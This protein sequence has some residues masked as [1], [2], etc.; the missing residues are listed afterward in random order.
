MRVLQLI[1]SSGYYGA[2]SMLVTL[3]AELSPAS[4]IATVGALRVG[5]EPEILLRAR[6]QGL[7]AVEFACNGRLD[8]SLGRRIADFLRREQ[9]D[10]LHTHGYK[11]N[12][13]GW[14]APKP[15]TT[16][17]ATCHNW[18][19]RSG[20]LGFYSVLDRLALR[21][22]PAV[23]AVSDG[24]KNRLADFGVTEPR[25]RVIPNGVDVRRFSQGKSTLR[26][27][28]GLGGRKIIGA[29]TRLTPGKGCD[30]LIAAMPK[31]L[32]KHPNATLVIVG[33]GP[34]EA[35]LKNQA[36][37]LG[38]ANRI[39]FAG[40]RADMPDVYASFDVFALASLDEGMPMSILEA[41]SAGVPVVATSVGAIPRLVNLQT[42]WIVP[43]GE[44]PPLAE[45]LSEALDEPARAGDR[46]QRAREHVEARYSAR[47]MAL[48]YMRLYQ[49]VAKRAQ[50][51][52]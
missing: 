20:S 52:A 45:A 43:P 26:D 24:V 21:R 15:R 13:Y 10:V 50:S 7:N 41:M 11:A 14:L 33:A 44:M 4:C 36:A 6:E 34:L 5:E 39:H 8:P 22:V 25:V 23:V 35:E 17:V 40:A 3:A 18:A 48:Q 32:G 9:I 47:A 28:L 49:E 1:S 31:V 29:V 46:A 19:V 37:A 42:G 12:L 51:A 27:E 30:I 2:E 16:Q 38:L